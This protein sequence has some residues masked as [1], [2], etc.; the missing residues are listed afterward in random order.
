M[1]SPNIKSPEL[2]MKPLGQTDEEKMEALMRLG[3][4]RRRSLFIVKMRD[5]KEK[6]DTVDVSAKEHQ[7]DKV[8]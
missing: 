5:R 8:A 4:S 6:G 3:L 7:K 1:I 2:S